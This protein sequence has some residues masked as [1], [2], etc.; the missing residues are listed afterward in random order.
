VV[1]WSDHRRTLLG[2][3]AGNLSV[4]STTHVMRSY[5]SRYP[6]HQARNNGKGP[7]G[8]ID[9][10]TRL[11]GSPSGSLAAEKNVTRARPPGGSSEEGEASWH[12]NTVL[13]ICFRAA[14]YA[15]EVSASVERKKV[16]DTQK[17]QIYNTESFKLPQQRGVEI[18]VISTQYLKTTS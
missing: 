18:E 17:L 1:Y 15:L 8:A 2:R 7:G 4:V 6:P 10:R 11:P 12:G 9:S 3:A 16:L 5:D 13:V 14:G